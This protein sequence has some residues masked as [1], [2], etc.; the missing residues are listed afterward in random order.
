MVLK[1]AIWLALICSF[2]VYFIPIVGPHAMFM[3]WESLGQR[4]G[5]F[6]KYPTWALT[7]LGVTLLLQAAAFGLFYWFW[8]R[9]SAHRLILLLGCGVAAVIE[10]QGHS[11]PEFL[12]AS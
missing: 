9:R 12:R 11:L 5:Q 6:S 3:I 1:K 2:S 7:E 4:F 10:V 8:R